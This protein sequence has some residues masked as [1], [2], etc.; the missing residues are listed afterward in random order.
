MVGR[1]RKFQ[2]ADIVEDDKGRLYVVVDHKTEYTVSYYRVVPVTRRFE[3]YGRAVWRTPQSLQATGRRS[4]SASVL[5]YRANQKLDEELEG[6]GC[7]C[8]CCIHYSLPT[9]DFNTRTGEYRDE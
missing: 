3:R 6:R 9:T 4:L 1:P 8:H 7:D 5:T 2:L